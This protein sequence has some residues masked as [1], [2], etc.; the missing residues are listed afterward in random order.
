MTPSRI[1][2]AR[3]A[4]GLTQA[5]LAKAIGVNVDTVRRAEQGKHETR[6]ITLIRMSR[7][8]GVPLEALVP[9]E[10]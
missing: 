6:I 1:A 4:A 3:R 5:E 8:L 9:D 2:T 7:A 10:H